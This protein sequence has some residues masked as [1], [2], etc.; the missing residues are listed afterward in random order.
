MSALNHEA[1]SLVAN[2]IA[3]A[4]DVDRALMGAMKVSIGPFG[5]MDRIGL[6]TVWHITNYWAN[7]RFYIRQIRKNAN[8][9][10]GYIDKGHLGVKSGQ[11]FY[12]Y[13]N[14]AFELPDFL[15]GE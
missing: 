2:G 11:G 7:R 10:K 15:E 12:T 5:N 9:I 6:D 3:S 4:K 14:P 8:F 13:P 1:L